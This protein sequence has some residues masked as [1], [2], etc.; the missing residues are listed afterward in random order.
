VGPCDFD[1]T[2]PGGYAAHAKLDRRSGDLHAVAYFW[3]WD[4]VQHVVVGADGRV[5]D[6]TDVPVADGPM[7][8]D[9]ALT[10][11]YVVLFDLPVTFSMD[12]AAAGAQLPYAWN[13][14]HPP[15]VGLLPREGTDRAVRWFPVDPCWVFHTLNAYDDGDR[16]VVDLCR[17]E[18]V[19]DL[20]SLA[21]QGPLTLDRWV[22]DPAAGTVTRQ[23]LDDRQQEF[24]R[25]D[26]RLL[27]RPHR[28]GYSAAF[29]PLSPDA[30]RPSGEVA[31]DAFAHAVLKHD[32]AAG[33][34]QA[35]DFGPDAVA[36]EA[37]FA[38]ASAEAAEDDGYV[39]TFVHEPER[40]ATDLVILAAQDFTGPPVARVHLPVRVPLGFHGSWLAD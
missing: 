1:G 40:G 30:V 22:I 28:Y 37:V 39:M 5:S 36:G 15:R 17:Y 7:M 14:A 16:V 12:A 6:A 31:D 35:H 26:D 11:R 3:G 18:G 32:L 8:H 24:P 10:E 2:L 33:T 23:C 19:Y 4:H 9:F 34:V 38:P 29:G 20:S 13:P 27:S 25:V 21:G